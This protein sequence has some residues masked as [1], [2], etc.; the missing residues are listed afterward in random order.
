MKSAIVIAAMMLAGCTTTLDI[1]DILVPDPPIPCPVCDAT[2]VG[3]HFEGQTCIKF[4]DG[5][6]RWVKDTDNGK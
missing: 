3:V 4:S 5:S 1:L 6:Y 2:T